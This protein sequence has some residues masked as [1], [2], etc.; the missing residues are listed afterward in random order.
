MQVLAAT[1]TPELINYSGQ[2]SALQRC[3]LRHS[4]D[5]LREVLQV[6]LAAGEKN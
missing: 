1:L 5:C 6:W 2:H 4:V 3:A